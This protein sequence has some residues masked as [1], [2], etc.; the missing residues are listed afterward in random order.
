MKKIINILLAAVLILACGC[1]KGE[2]ETNNSDKIVYVTAD[3][4]THSFGVKTTGGWSVSI[5][6]ESKEWCEFEGATSGKGLGAFTIRYKENVFDGVRRGLRRQALL[7]V[8]TDDQ[9]TSTTIYLRQ[10]G[11]TP[12]LE[13][14]TDIANVSHKD[15]E[16]TI[17]INTNLSIHESEDI[18]YTI[19]GG[20]WLQ[21]Q[22]FNP[23]GT[24]IYFAFP[25]NESKENG[26]SAKI[27]ISYV[28]AWGETF[29]DSIDLV[30]AVCPTPP[31][32]F[33]DFNTDEND[34]EF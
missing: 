28:D 2:I 5:D 8:I 32:L 13:F 33:E 27:S 14:R 34:N 6:E 15:T 20:E 31:E 10:S 22:V 9:F 29:G 17:D 1:Q 11:I 16:T 18:V 23:N 7:K 12:K 26:R 25:E 3:E 19:S 4:G 21:K 24:S 30:Q